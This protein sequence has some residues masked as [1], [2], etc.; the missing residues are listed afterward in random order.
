MPK[1]NLAMP[2]THSTSRVLLGSVSE[3]SAETG[4]HLR[5]VCSLSVRLARVLGVVGDAIEE[6]RYGALLHDIGKQSIPSE[7]LHKPGRLEP[8]ELMVMRTH[9][10]LGAE[11]AERHGFGAGIISVIKYHHE[12]YDG[13]GYPEGFA[14]DDIPLG[15]RIV[16]AV[17]TVDTILYE[18]SYDDARPYEVA[19]SELERCAGTQFDPTVSR[20]LSELL[21]EI[22]E[23]RGWLDSAAA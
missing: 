3:F 1:E 4:S 11:I 18:R 12:Q 23:S 17:D 7:I 5:R 19:Q 21:A 10:Q 20:A 13:E 8:S 14:G 6:I 15:A 9:C 22:A 2:P 16:A